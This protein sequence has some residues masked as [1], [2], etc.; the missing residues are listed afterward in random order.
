MHQNMSKNVLDQKMN[1]VGQFIAIQVF[2]ILHA[3]NHKTLILSPEL[4]L[5]EI[6]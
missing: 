6:Y 5:S 3:W 4:A 2:L 1:H